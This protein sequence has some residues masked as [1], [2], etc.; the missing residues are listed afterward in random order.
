MAS[1][2]NAK[3]NADLNEANKIN[4]SQTEVITRYQG[5]DQQLK[6]TQNMCD[7]KNQ[8][9]Q[10]MVTSKNQLSSKLTELEN[11]NE[12]QLKTIQDRETKLENATKVIQ[13]L[14]ET[15]KEYKQNLDKY[16]SEN[17]EV[18]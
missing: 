11:K 10:N 5:L 8:E 6:N 1:C 12:I 18:V 15:N 3:L 16:Q 9:Y 4:Q 14:T 2:D 7:E 17:K 13:R